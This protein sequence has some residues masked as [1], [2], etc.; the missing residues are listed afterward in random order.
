MA[1]PT[2]NEEIRM[3]I[4]NACLMM[5]QKS[6]DRRDAL[7][8]LYHRQEREKELVAEA[9][10]EAGVKEQMKRLHKVHGVA[11]AT[12]QIMKILDKVAAAGDRAAVLTQVGLLSK[13][14][15][16]VDKDLVTL[17]QEAEATAGQQADDQGSVF[18][19]TSE[20]QRRG[21]ATAQ[22]KPVE[23]KGVDLPA[24]VSTPGVPLDEALKQLEAYNAANPP[25]RGAKPAERKRLEAQVEAAKS[26]HNA[27]ETD[28]LA[29]KPEAKPGEITEALREG[30]AGSEAHIRDQAAKP[31]NDELPPAAPSRGQQKAAAPL[32]DELPPPAP[33]RNAAHRGLGPDAIH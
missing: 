15:G 2:A 23:A 25:K 28:P 5:P 33:R 29:D 12:T 10:D 27:A 9:R 7:N 22:P 8:E 19:N 14:V 18:D 21:G 3:G 26:A 6:E 13:D 20:G 30:N 17:A 16:Y 4:A 24:H 11:K 1:N 32:D 31:A